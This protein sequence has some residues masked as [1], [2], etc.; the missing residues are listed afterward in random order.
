MAKALIRWRSYKAA[1]NH[2]HVSE[3]SLRRATYW[4]RLFRHD[5]GIYAKEYEAFRRKMRP[6]F[7]YLTE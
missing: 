6:P 1:A 5:V 2:L 7:D 4:M 3:E